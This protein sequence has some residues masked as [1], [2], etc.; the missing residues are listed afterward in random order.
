MA[1]AL[2]K[3]FGEINDLTGFNPEVIKEAGD[4]VMKAVNKR[5]DPTSWM[6]YAGTAIKQAWSALPKEIRQQ[7]YNAIND[8]IQAA[9]EQAEFISS[10]MSEV[11]E[12]MNALPIIGA[13][14]GA[15]IK[16][17]G[18]IV[19]AVKSTQAVN[20]GISGYHQAM[21]M[22]LTFDSYPDP[23]DWV[24]KSM[25][26]E[27]YTQ[28]VK[29][30]KQGN[31]SRQ[32]CF[33]RAGLATN[34]MFAAKVGVP[35][36]GKCG[37]KKGVKMKCPQK[38]DFGYED[39]DRFYK[40]QSKNPSSW[41][42]RHLGISALF[43]PY[44]S[45]TYA[46]EPINNSYVGTDADPNGI[47]M[48]RQTMLL[49]DPYS[50]LRVVSAELLDMSDR[51]IAF[52]RHAME[53]FAVNGKKA[54]LRIDENGNA[55]GTDKADRYTIDEQRDPNYTGS[56]SL[57][58][59]FYFDTDGRIV[60]YPGMKAGVN[61]WGIRVS[62]GAHRGTGGGSL[63]VSVGAYNAVITN[64]L[65]FFTA[66]SNMLRNGNRMRG[67]LMDHAKGDLDPAVRAAVQYA[68]DKGGMLPGPGVPIKQMKF[69]AP[70]P[71]I[72]TKSMAGKMV[73]LRLMPKRSRFNIENVTPLKGEK[74]SGSVMPLL[75]GVAVLGLVVLKN[76]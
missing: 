12:N 52:W 73:A 7:M 51:F 32:P 55:P 54:L 69:Q 1:N 38:R 28:Y 2:E 30:R 67:L 45:P 18:E 21:R 35:D 22:S 23:R 58:N 71:G 46:A 40:R 56:Q 19:S 31:W 44:W 8:V 70:E 5:N 39:C 68:A 62:G 36:V 57:M 66:R 43:Y 50:N 17:I 6:A 9:L 14:I 27:N 16:L 75:L 60:P 49:T 76:K 3:Y 34:R 47:L 33:R 37:H 72:L 20:K 59:R 42:R 53:T 29:S 41:C 13:I 10:A 48:G 74:S 15:V 63:A 26:L 24:F 4:A 25:K 64:T 61:E 11:A 65:A